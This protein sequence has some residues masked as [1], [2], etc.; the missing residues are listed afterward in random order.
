MSVPLHPHIQHQRTVYELVTGWQTD[1]DN[2][3]DQSKTQFFLT[4]YISGIQ[5]PCTLLNE[6]DWR[7]SE[8]TKGN[9][10]D[11]VK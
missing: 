5:R 4:R 10:Q 8:P 3:R 1:K 2:L 7:R 6:P 9:R 11:Q